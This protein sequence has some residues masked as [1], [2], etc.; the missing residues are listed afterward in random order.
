MAHYT[1]P[2]CNFQ[3][4]LMCYFTW[5]K[6]F[7]D[8]IK[9]LNL[10]EILWVRASLV[11]LMLKICLKRGRLGFNPFSWRSNTLATWCK[12]LTHWKR[13]WCWE[14]LKAGGEGD[15][16]GWDGWM[17]SLTQWTWVWANTG[18]KWRTGKPGTWQSM[19]LQR[20]GQD[21]ATKQQRQP[22]FIQMSPV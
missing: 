8:V 15:D 13:S 19:G 7:E 9:D 21:L 6:N 2:H 14:R 5:Q 10:W 18:R 17:A 16:R 1:W 20:E 12:E 11:V 22:W 3:N 4:L